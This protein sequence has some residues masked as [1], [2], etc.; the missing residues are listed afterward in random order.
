MKGLSAVIGL[1]SVAALITGSVIAEDYVSDGSV[2][3]INKT[4]PPIYIAIEKKSSEW[5]LKIIH[6]TDDAGAAGPHENWVEHHYSPDEVPQAVNLS[7]CSVDQDSERPQVVAWGLVDAPNEKELCRLPSLCYIDVLGASGFHRSGVW[8]TISG[9]DQVVGDD[10]H[11]VL[12]C[13]KGF[14][15]FAEAERNVCSIDLRPRKGK[16]FRLDQV[17]RPTTRSDAVNDAVEKWIDNL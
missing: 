15:V 7:A 8:K 5:C 14:G 1:I 17:S 11:F 10:E 9:T 6:G 16:L 4:D 2:W 13:K 12:E 3:Y